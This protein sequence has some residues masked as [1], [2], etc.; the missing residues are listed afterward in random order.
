MMMMQQARQQGM[1][2][3]QTCPPRGS[4]TGGMEYEIETGIPSVLTPFN[5][6]TNPYFLPSSATS[7]LPLESPSNIESSCMDRTPFY[8]TTS[9]RPEST[10]SQGPMSE[11]S[12]PTSIG[13]NLDEPTSLIWKFFQQSFTWRESTARVLPSK[14]VQS[15]I[16]EEVMDCGSSNSTSNEWFLFSILIPQFFLVMKKEIVFLIVCL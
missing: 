16:T 2:M 1:Q 7:R 4:N 12:F 9:S 10:A 8:H 15:H 5:P 14:V 11:V 13:V 6:P 3:M